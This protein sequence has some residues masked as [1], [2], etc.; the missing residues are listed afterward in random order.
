MGRVDVSC[1]FCGKGLNDIAWAE[2]GLTG[3]ERLVSGSSTKVTPGNLNKTSTGHSCGR[4]FALRTAIFLNFF[5]KYKTGWL[6][7]DYGPQTIIYVAREIASDQL[8]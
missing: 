3:I 5:L 4:V 6:L 2:D 1:L 8:R 7:P